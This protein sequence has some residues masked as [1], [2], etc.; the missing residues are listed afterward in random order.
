MRPG[1][2]RIR[3]AYRV[4]PLEPRVLLS[5][6]PVFLPIKE[7]L[8]SQDPSLQSWTQF[9]LSDPV[10][11]SQSA[12][13]ALLGALTSDAPLQITPGSAIT[14]EPTVDLS[15]V[16]TTQALSVDAAL[17]APAPV[18]ASLADAESLSATSPST[19]TNGT[20]ISLM[21][22]GAQGLSLLLDT[23]DASASPLA[24]QE[25][26]LTLAPG[27][28]AVPEVQPTTQS[29]RDLLA[30]STTDLAKLTGTLDGVSTLWVAP[31]ATLKGSG[32]WA[33]DL[34][35][36]GL[37]SPG[38]SPGYQNYNTLTLD[39]SA[40]TLFE[41]GGASAASATGTGTGYYDQ[42]NVT[43]LAA[44]DGEIQVQLLY[45]YRP[46]DG[47]VFNVLNYG[48]YSGAFSKGSGLID[49][50]NGV[51][52]EILSGATSISLKAHVLDA[53]T[54]YL[55]G[56]LTSAVGADDQALEDR[57]GVWLNY[58]YFRNNTSF[59][60]TGDL[61]LGD[62]LNLSGS[63]TI[64]YTDHVLV[65]SDYVDVFT[66]GL[67]N[68]SGHLGSS[69]ARLGFSDADLGILLMR[70]ESATENA[71]WI[72]A[73]GQVG[74][75]SLSGT[76]PVT[77]SA[78]S[79]SVDLAQG[80]GTRSGGAAN[81]TVLDLSANARSL[82]VGSTTYAFDSSDTSERVA[83]SG[84][85][86]LAF[87]NWLSLSGSMGFAS[88]SS[89]LQVA[90]QGLSANIQAGSVGM[91]IRNGSFGL[92]LNNDGSYALEAAGGLYLSGG[93][94]AQVS[95]DMALL[96]LN[97]TGQALQAQTLTIG[98]LS[99]ALPAFGAQSTPVLQVSGL[100]A[101]IGDAIVLAGDFAF[102]RDSSSGNL[103]V[104]ASSASASLRAGD[105]HAGVSNASVALVVKTS[106]IVLEASGAADLALGDTLSAS[107][108]SVRVAWNSTASAITDGTQ[109][110]IANASH[111]FGALQAGQRDV[112]LTDA[113]VVVSDFFRLD[114]SLTLHRSTQTVQLA[115]DTASTT[116]VN[117]ATEGLAVDLFALG[118]TGLSAQV[119]VADGVGLSLTDRKSVV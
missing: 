60:F 16:D 69:T 34:T 28:L 52:F 109:I 33:G 98:N 75:V 63:A 6:D 90:G 107:A 72:W 7:A 23:A 81:T 85:V 64:G 116:G 61:N 86:N 113:H 76:D 20:L 37:L 89:G 70:S 4:E 30:G 105:V 117:E 103:E 67:E 50:G 38:Y 82:S 71:G 62:G 18:V 54:S 43:G 48:S 15:S 66:L 13:G 101:R 41:I 49:A 96:R 93:G 87:S 29:R 22:A 77:L 91:G 119:G 68:A 94:F 74:G 11:D 114:G 46:T 9:T 111:T 95:A 39:A 8:D 88:G 104:L 115:A 32:A 100:S 36:D 53:T 2:E 1:L 14:V 42:I 97:S 79:L 5:A 31:D 83:L 45:G 19:N 12:S 40:V 24:P 80:L 3:D 112:V 35:V 106:G 92:L 73:E 118:G 44:L 110:A 10:Y 65:G 99:Y 84:T 26:A 108:A 51:F 102:E 58:D 57:V 56:A 55:V 47:Q 27:A 25:W 78:T 21:D 59:S 17:A